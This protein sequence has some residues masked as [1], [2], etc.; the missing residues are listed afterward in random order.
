MIVVDGSPCQEFKLALRET[1]VIIVDQKEP[2]MGASRRQVLNEGI[3]NGAK[4][5]VW[6]EPEKHTLI[7]L[8]E[9]CIAP[10]LC[11][12][13]D[14]V[15]PRR[16]N[17]DGYPPYQQLSEYRGNWDLA[18]TTGRPDLD[19]FIGVRI[20]TIEAAKLM[21]N[22]DGQCGNNTYGDNW[23]ILFIPILWFM[24]KG[25]QIRSVT[26]NYIHPPEQLVEEGQDMI[27]KRDKQRID[28]VGAMAR[29]F[30]RHEFEN[31]L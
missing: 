7:P 18:N 23:E 9:P 20:M 14:V 6:L 30:H 25:L 13:V 27:A 29:E 16:L 28:L 3:N 31:M 22:Y 15:V 8:L 2:G 12:G 1:G 26:V 11:D 4:V 17:L 19:L 21:A 24:R 5:I 10:V